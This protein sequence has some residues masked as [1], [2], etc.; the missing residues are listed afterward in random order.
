MSRNSKRKIRKGDLKSL[1]VKTTGDLIADKNKAD[2]IMAAP[3]FPT[4]EVPLAKVFATKGQNCQSGNI[5]KC[6]N[7]AWCAKCIDPSR[8][9]TAVDKKIIVGVREIID[10]KAYMQH[11]KRI[12]HIARTTHM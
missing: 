8:I 7:F 9:E 6:Q 4:K 11:S 12:E 1:I 10:C 2:I 5:D 3:E